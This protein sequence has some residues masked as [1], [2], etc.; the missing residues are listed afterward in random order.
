MISSACLQELIMWR[1]FGYRSMPT[2]GYGGHTFQTDY[3]PRKS[4]QQNLNCFC[5]LRRPRDFMFLEPCVY[6]HVTG[7]DQML[8]AQCNEQ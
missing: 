3:T 5:L 4:F 6:I 2:A 8:K 1:H 7:I